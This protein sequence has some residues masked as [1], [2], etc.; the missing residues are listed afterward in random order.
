MDER[1]KTIKDLETRKKADLA[2]VDALLVQLGEALLPRMQNEVPE[3]GLLMRDIHDSEE[4]IA[5]AQADIAR[6]KKLDEDIRRKEQESSELNK[7]IFLLHTR[8]GELVL[9]DPAFGEFAGPYRVQVE[10][11]LPKI[12]SLEGRIETLGEQD[13]PN[14]FAWIGKGAQGMVLRSFL[15]RN[16][17]NLQR[18]FNAAGEKFVQDAPKEAI[19]NVF[20]LDMLGEINGSR[21]TQTAAQTEIALLKEERRRVTASFAPD[22][23][24]SRKISALERHI[25]ETREKLHALFLHSGRLVSESPEQ[26]EYAVM[27]ENA[28]HQLLDQVAALKSAVEENDRHAEKLR[29]SLAIDEEKAK[30]G[31]MERSIVFHRRHIAESE[32]N[33]R[34]LDAR[35]LAANKRIEELSKSLE[36]PLAD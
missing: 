5:A 7:T 2:S 30:I 16:K 22:G 14:V 23:G 24:V 32:E 9:Q 12:Q 29:A 3:Y 34:E 31:K 35:I 6:L 19:D 10:T 18:I 21:E 36:Q 26:P 25:A 28:D 13:G 20:V 17:S 4:S 27:L 15:G 33:I 1:K 11:L 8:I